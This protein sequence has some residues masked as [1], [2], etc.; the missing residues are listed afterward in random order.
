[1]SEKELYDILVTM[2]IPVAYDHFEQYPDSK[3]TLPFIIYRNNDSFTQKAE[4]TTW[5]RIN[6]YIVDLATEK[7]DTALEA[8]LENL[9]TTYNLPFDKE[10]DYLEDERIYQIRYF[11][12]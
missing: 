1:M 10:E 9:F 7:K 11:I 12:C 5:L 6:N 3:V 8:T 2:K 4:D